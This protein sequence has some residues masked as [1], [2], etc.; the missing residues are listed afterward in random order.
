MDTSP[1]QALQNAHAA[2]AAGD[3]PAAQALYEHFFDHALEIDES[4]YGVRLS[5]CLNEWVKLAKVY[6]PALENLE[7]RAA[8]AI[9]GF[10][11]AQTP[12]L[13][14]DYQ[15]ILINL[16]REETVLA[17]LIGYHKTRPELAVIA[18][19]TMWR[20]LVE[21]K[22]WDLC[23]VFTLAMQRSDTKPLY[24]NS[25]LE[26]RLPAKIPHLK[27]QASRDPSET[28]TLAMSATCSAC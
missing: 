6:P 26:C 5:F 18:A 3:Y 25:T 14:H 24:S 10:E 7:A 8:E 27:K 23:A 11:A 22:R 19:E 2:M 9:A 28:A 21:A 17:R 1:R 4:F 15:A 20:K 12:A 13:F 16:D